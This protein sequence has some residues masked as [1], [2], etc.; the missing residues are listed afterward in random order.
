MSESGSLSPKNPR[1]RTYSKEA[2]LFYRSHL[3]E[4][5][6][7]LD[8]A[9]AASLA[10]S[11]SAASKPRRA[12][13]FVRVKQEGEE[14]SDEWGKPFDDNLVRLVLKHA[15]EQLKKP[16]EF[17]LF[18]NRETEQWTDVTGTLDLVDVDGLLRT[19]ARQRRRVLKTKDSATNGNKEP[20]AG[21]SAV[22]RTISSQQNPYAAFSATG[23]EKQHMSADAAGHPPEGFHAGHP[24]YPGM[25]MMP[26]MMP[27]YPYPYPMM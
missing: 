11:I 19:A 26:G 2:L 15:H 27:G 17:Q 24:A 18:R 22:G 14:F 3:D 13:L 20:A 1:E 23:E 8:Q 6:Q 5:A 25:M 12:D 4:T 9:S 10:A 7:H 16:S 21:P